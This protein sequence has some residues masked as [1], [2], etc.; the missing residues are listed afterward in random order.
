[1]LNVKTRRLTNEGMLKILCFEVEKLLKGICSKRLN[2]D[3]KVA[4]GDCHARDAT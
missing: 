4:K 2:D 1:M 3:L